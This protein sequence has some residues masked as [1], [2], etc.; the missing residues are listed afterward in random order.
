MV[1]VLRRVRKAP[2]LIRW[3]LLFLCVLG[4]AGCQR[5]EITVYLAP[6]DTPPPQTATAESH[7]DVAARSRPRPQ[8]T[9]KLPQGWKE[10]TPNEISLASFRI[11]G[12]DGKDAEVSITELSNLSG[13]EAALVNMW[14]SRVGQGPLASEEALKLLQPVEVGGEQGSLFEV[15][16]EG[17]EDP[18]KIVTAMV[19][20][21]EGSWF[22]KLSGDA[23]LVSE[24]KSVFLEFLK[25]IQL[26]EAAPASSAAEPQ[27]VAD[28]PNWSVPDRWQ[29]VPAGQMQFARFAMPQ[30]GGAK[31]EVFVSVFP[32]DTGGQLANVNRWRHQ[33]GLD[34]LGAQDLAQ[35][36]SPLDGAAPGAILVDMTNNDKRLIGAV[37]PRDGQYWFY[38]LLGDAAAVAPERDAFVAFAKSKP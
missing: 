33:I 9:W 24:Q 10:G 11:F 7:Q 5:K 28:K 3:W 18:V 6:K 19:H 22:F 34:P 1:N 17:I 25:S 12:K 29:E 4:L 37:V 31:A 16:G 30:K 14:R 36:V 38:K 8:I 21:P 2:S 13:K 20:H 23:G 32:S 26:K 15:S 27:A 35:A